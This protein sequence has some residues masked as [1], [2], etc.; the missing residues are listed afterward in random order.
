MTLA[1]IK[2]SDKTMLTP[3]DIAEVIGVDAQSIREAAKVAPVLLGFPVVRVG[4]RTRIPRKAFLRYMG[5][6]E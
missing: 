4:T 5:E 2:E 1:E 3:A 6:E